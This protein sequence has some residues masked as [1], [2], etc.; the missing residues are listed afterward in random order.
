MKNFFSDIV[1]NRFLNIDSDSKKIAQ[2]MFAVGLFLFLSKMIGA[3]KEIALA[4]RFGVSEYVDAYLFVFALVLWPVQIW[5]SV[6]S[7]V[8]IPLDA[9]IREEKPDRLRLFHGELFGATFL[10]SIVVTVIIWLGYPWLIKQSIIGFTPRVENISLDMLNILIWIIPIALVSRL[11]ST[12]IMSKGRM[13]NSLFE[14]L[15]PLTILIF[16]VFSDSGIY[17]LIWG[18]LVGF[19][20]EALATFTF[21]RSIGGVNSFFIN[22]N[23]EIWVEFLKGFGIIFL[24]HFLLSLTTIVDQFFASNLGVGA[25]SYLG[26][27]TRI[28]SIILAI[29]AT[30]IGRSVLPVLSRVY[31]EGRSNVGRLVIRWSGFLFVI[32][33]VIMII[34]MVFSPLIVEKI[35]Q[36]GAFTSADTE[37]VAILLRYGLSQ[38][39]FYFVSM[40]L[41]Q[42]L[43]SQSL[44]RSVALISGMNLVVKLLSASI[45]VPKMGI[46]GLLLSTAVVFLVSMILSFIVFFNRLREYN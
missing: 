12:W 39:P 41:I 30:S 6:I 37:Q 11:F 15:V 20:I 36:R 4:W 9:K 17:S 19:L 35:F 44:F 38:V 10:F 21:L 8:I 23:S 16:I 27:T 13:V 42:T 40:I 33:L 5:Y 46:N 24:G 26:Y 31:Y 43:L 34:G 7:A 2:G 18:S 28:L 1:K 25:L 3:L 32:G 22:F 45:L 29:G 14:G